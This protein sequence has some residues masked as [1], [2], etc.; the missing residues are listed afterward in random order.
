MIRRTAFTELRYSVLRLIGTVLGLAVLFIVPPLWFMCGL[1]FTGI[2]GGEALS[3][4]PMLAFEGLFAWGVMARTYWP[5]VHFFGINR[6][7]TL[8]LP[9]AG[10][11]YGAMTLDSA[12]R[13][14]TGKNIGW[15]DS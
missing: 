14:W 7:W 5:A 3:F 12:V 6:T 1:F 13:Y 10:I 2:G 8:A 9:I 15:R 11:F 4:A